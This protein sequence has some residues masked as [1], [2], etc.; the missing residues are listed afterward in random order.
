MLPTPERPTI[1]SDI[2]LMSWRNVCV[3]LW[4]A[5]PTVAGV[6]ALDVHYRAMAQANP[7]GFAVCVIVADDV[8]LPDE[9][10]RRSISATMSSIGPHVLGMCGVHETKGFRGAAIRSVLTAMVMMSRAP[11]KTIT[12]ATTD[13]AA[14]WLAKWVDPEA[15]PSELRGIIGQ[16]RKVVE[17]RHP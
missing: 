17:A 3:A 4:H 13:H 7:N 11:Y 15:T 2:A 5:D 8:S 14:A 12:V 16:F 10:V 1:H 9:Q 6:D